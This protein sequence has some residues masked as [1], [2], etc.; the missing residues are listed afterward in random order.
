[1]TLEDLH[2]K[3]YKLEKLLETEQKHRKKLEKELK[4]QKLFLETAL[5]SSPSAII[6][7]N[8][9]GEIIYIN[10]AAVDFYSNN[11]LF[12]K[13]SNKEI[14]DSCIE[15]YPNGEIYKPDEK[16]LQKALKKGIVTKNVEVLIELGNGE[17]KWVLANAAPIIIDNE[18]IA[19]IVIFTDITK[20]KRY[21]D[22]LLQVTHNMTTIFEH[23]SSILLLVNQERKVV[24]INKAGI[25]FTGKNPSEIINQ[26][27]GKALG[28]YV[29]ESS[30]KIDCGAFEQCIDC[31]LNNIIN[32]SILGKCSNEK[33]EILFKKRINNQIV[34]FYMDISCSNI[35][36]SGEEL[37]VLTMNDITQQKENEQKLLEL[38]S[39]KDRFFSII[40]HDLKNP[41]GAVSGIAEL[42][43]RRFENYS[44]EK[45]YKSV[46]II[47]KNLKGILQLLMN[48]L[49]WSRSQRGIKKAQFK[50]YKINTLIKETIDLQKP[51]LVNKK[52]N[53]NL[54]IHDNISVICDK[55]MINTILRNLIQNA[56]K[57]TPKGNSIFVFTELNNKQIIVNVKDTGIGIPSN[58]KD[59][60]FK[61]EKNYSRQG[62]ENEK[63]TGLGLI[64][65]KEF[66]EMHKQSIWFE[67]EEGLGST[68]AF[69]LK[70]KK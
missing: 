16:P 46:Q 13:D 41:I 9:S 56:I 58:M 64:I 21:E 35:Q 55:E 1:M 23:T 26:Y 53:L 65:C 8:E 39:T 42:L 7:E 6:I 11:L 48:L 49:E 27:Q 33:K 62:T 5:H 4:E 3:I 50:T 28:C 34:K 60:L 40:S 19:A 47:N 43:E 14:L 44:E 18:I 52:I 54:D 45:K 68:F 10:Q 2:Q 70:I 17:L 66:I 12:N 22:N 69:S 38:N 31:Q 57:F 20:R 15:Y 37:L 24:N 29:A 61:I 67:S 30:E 51:N 59:N 25:E 63:G 32:K 36:Y